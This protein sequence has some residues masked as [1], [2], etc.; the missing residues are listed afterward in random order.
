[1]TKLLGRVRIRAWSTRDRR[2]SAEPTTEDVVRPTLVEEYEGHED[3]RR[4]R[5]DLERVVR[6]RCVIDRE[7]IAEVRVR[8]HHARVEAR[9]K[10]RDH[11]NCTQGGHGER[12]AV[13]RSDEECP[14]E[15]KS[16]DSEDRRK[17]RREEILVV[18]VDRDC[19][20]PDEESCSQEH[21]GDREAT[22][23]PRRTVTQLSRG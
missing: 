14:G 16:G 6:R 22:R 8:D 2:L 21:R 3:Q 20:S 18:A 5:H 4:D 9:E 23:R 11:R 15:N 12:A 10:R 17:Y 13:L 1:M 7:A 19:D